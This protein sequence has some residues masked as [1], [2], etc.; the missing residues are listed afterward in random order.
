MIDPWAGSYMMETLTQDVYDAAKSIID[1]VEAMGGMAKAV[2]TGW[3]KLKIEECAAK[4]QAM[5]D[6]GKEVIVGVN[7]HQLE[8]EDQ[9][10]VLVIDN[11]EVRKKQI[12]RLKLL[13]AE[14]DQSKVKS[15]LDALVVAAK[16]SNNIM[17]A[18]VEATRCRASVGE[19]SDALEEVF[20]RHTAASRLVSGA[21]KSEYG[22]NDEIKM[23]IKRVYLVSFYSLI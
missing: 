18:A 20:G 15:A 22:E 21:Y 2:G 5:I 7:K 3:A 10:D 19:I 11:E 4:R 23:I 17:E 1:E 12:D 13:R 14:R 8:K 9:L 6:S 16:S